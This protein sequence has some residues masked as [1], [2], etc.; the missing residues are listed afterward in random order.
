MQDIRVTKGQCEC[1]SEGRDI[2]QGDCNPAHPR[3]SRRVLLA[4]AIGMI[5][6]AELSDTIPNHRGQNQRQKNGKGA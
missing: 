6:K 2:G 3:Y 1:Q 4:N 5:Q